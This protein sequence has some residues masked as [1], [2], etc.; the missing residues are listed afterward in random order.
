MIT[1]LLNGVSLGAILFLIGSG[2]SLVLGS[3]GIINLAHGALY[4]VGAYIGW[5]VVMKLDA[6]FWLAIIAGAA[7][8]AIVGLLMHQVFFKHLSE[9]LD[10]QIL[11]SFGL[12]FI[13]ADAAEW[14]WGPNAKPPFTVDQLGGSVDLFGLTYPVTRV[15]IIV[16]GLVFVALLW[17]LQDRTRMGAIVRGGMDDPQMVE[18]MGINL[19][20]VAAT[21]FV[22]GS[23]VAGAAGVIGGLV[24]GAQ[25]AFGIDMML[26]ALVVVVL[27]GVGSI[28]GA[29]AGAVIVGITQSVSVVL[30]PSFSAFS[31]YV[32]MAI[33]LLVRPSGLTGRVIAA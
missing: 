23:A 28:P 20:L 3:M 2:L 15:F 19:K 11:I 31:L 26:L 14:I 7:A 16:V 1:A 24:M 25:P 30:F 13:L 8:A 5:S 9:L 33:V 6:G 10:E 17:W 29:L 22:V 18:S 21:L 27:G 32:V 12:V 4:M